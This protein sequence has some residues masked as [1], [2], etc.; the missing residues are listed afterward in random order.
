MTVNVERTFADSTAAR[1]RT[2]AGDGLTVPA[3]WRRERE[4]WCRLPRTAA[5]YGDAAAYVAA[6]LLQQR[7]TA[8]A[9]ARI[10]THGAAVFRRC[11]ATFVVLV[12][13]I[14][15]VCS[16]TAA[17]GALRTVVLLPGA[18]HMPWRAVAAF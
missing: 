6:D 4:R 18:I 1:L 7:F 14:G 16:V 13:S 9:V 17:R 8:S 5:W 10:P 3:R 12:L 11:V 2:T 15:L